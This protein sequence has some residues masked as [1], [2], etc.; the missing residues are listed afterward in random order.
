MS[1]PEGDFTIELIGLMLDLDD[2][3]EF[4]EVQTYRA[5]FGIQRD[6]RRFAV[7]V[8][9]DRG[10]CRTAD[11][12]RVAMSRLHGVLVQLARQT[13]GWRLDQTAVQ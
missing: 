3:D 4:D 13:D 11:L 2:E 9:F 6:D 1:E 8:W 7:T 5:S 12:I 10:D